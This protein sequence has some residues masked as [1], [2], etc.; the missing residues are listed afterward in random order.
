MKFLIRFD[1][2]ALMREEISECCDV[3]ASMSRFVVGSLTGNIVSIAYTL[4]KLDNLTGSLCQNGV[5]SS[6][7][8]ATRE[9]G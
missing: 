3:I 2:I 7:G 8:S 4:A 9:K 6:D 1:K 5:K